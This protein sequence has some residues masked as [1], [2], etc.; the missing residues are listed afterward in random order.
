MLCITPRKAV[1]EKRY[2]LSVGI[3]S[4]EGGA[5]LRAQILGRS[6]PVGGAPMSYGSFY[7]TFRPPC[8]SSK[9]T[10]PQTA[11]R[12]SCGAAPCVSAIRSSAMAAAASRRTT[13]ITTGS[14]SGGVAAPIAGRPSPFCRCFLCLTPTTACWLAVRRYDG[15]GRSTAPR[16]TRHPR[17]T[18]PIASPIPP[19]SAAGR[20][21]WIL[22]SLPLPFCARRWPVSLLG[23]HA[24]ITLISRLGRYLG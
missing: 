17:S 10:G 8:T 7:P 3:F 2:S 21:V 22:P 19:R 4:S 1:V 6:P 23:C 16:K 9:P 20:A 18:T 24:A 15:V 5:P 11:P 14:G 12:S 13:N